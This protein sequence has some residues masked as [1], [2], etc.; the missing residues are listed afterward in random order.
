MKE[1]YRRTAQLLTQPEDTPEARS[2]RQMSTRAYALQ[3]EAKQP[4]R[5][6]VG[7]EVTHR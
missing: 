3:T 5:V 7:V 6:E 1:L 2:A 4:E